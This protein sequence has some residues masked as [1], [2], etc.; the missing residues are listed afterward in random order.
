MEDNIENIDL[1]DELSALVNNKNLWW[2]QYNE[3]T[4]SIKQVQQFIKNIRHNFAEQSKAYQ[5][6]QSKKNRQKR[7]AQMIAVL[8]NYRNDRDSWDRMLLLFLT[9]YSRF[10][11]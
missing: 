7:V 5:Q 8:L 10:K 2:H 4:E 9:D 3:L 1:S 6:I 11:E